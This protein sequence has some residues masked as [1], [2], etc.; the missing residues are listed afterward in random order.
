LQCLRE[1]QYAALFDALSPFVVTPILDGVFLS[2][3]PSL[4][5]KEGKVAD[6]AI[7]AGANTDEGTATFFGPRNSL[8]SDADVVAYLR[9]MG[10]GLNNSTIADIMAL[11]PDDPTLGCP[12]NT[13][14]GRFPENGLQYKRGAAIAG[15]Q[16]IHAGRR[17]TAKYFASTDNCRK[18][19]YSYRFDQAPWN[20]IEPLVATAAPVYSTHYAEICFVFNIDPTASR[21]NTNWIGPYPEYYHLS[22]LMSRMF[23]SF[24]HDACPNNHGLE[25]VPYWPEYGSG[26]ENFVFKTNGSWVEKDDYRVPQLE[27]WN[28]IWPSLQS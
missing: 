11:Y 27:Y 22:N 23:I 18:P 26:Q 14:S 5:F 1:V 8:N 15:D 19:V 28:D 13:G 12:Y 2:Q 9:K 7:L 25:G 24:V 10:R 16:A 21:N 20:N 4:S 17:A 6:V 3:L